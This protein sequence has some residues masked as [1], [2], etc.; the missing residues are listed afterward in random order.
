MHLYE[1]LRR[2]LVTEKNTGLQAEGKYVFEVAGEANKRQITQAVEKAFKV[3]VTTV[4]VMT[5]PGKRRRVGRRQVLT[6]S[7]KKAIV[8]LQSGDKIE[9]FEGV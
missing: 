2:P 6:Q 8:T 3:K 1:V 4:N 5:V 9:F 7:W